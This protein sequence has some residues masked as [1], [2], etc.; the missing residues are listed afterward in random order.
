MN[1]K[2]LLLT[3]KTF[4]ATGG[5]EKVCKVAGKALYEQTL[6]GPV[7][8]QIHSMYDKQSDADDNKYFPGE[9]FR[10][11]GVNKI[12]FIYQSVREGCRSNTVILSHANLLL[13]GWL[14]KL[15]SP[16]TKLMLFAHGIE[17]WDKLGSLKTS[18]LKSCDSVLSVSNYTSQRVQQTHGIA[19]EKCKVLNNSLDPYLPIVSEADRQQLAETL[20]KHYGYSKDDKI[21]FTLTRLSSKERYKGY[22][23]VL[24]ALEGVVKKYPTVQYLIAGKYDEIEKENLL[25]QAKALGLEKNLKIAGFIPDDSLTAHFSMSDLYVMPSRKEGFGIV[26][27]EAMYYG[28]PVIAGN[29]DGSVDA[30]LNG[31]LGALVNPL[32]VAEIENSILNILNNKKANKPNRN[33]M[34]E[35]FGYE[36]YKRKMADLMMS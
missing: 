1:T 12:K 33:L 19:A 28:V 17:I 5:I 10:G 20:R 31:Q 8:F 34:L 22:D 11:F 25:A 15:F 4:S 23:K 14:I 26:F 21:I 3:L 6:T 16:K 32:D 30:L 18:M 2:I 13:V 27:V 7:S 9:H 36:G 35:S 24:E 29:H